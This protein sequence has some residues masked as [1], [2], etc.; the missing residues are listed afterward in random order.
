MSRQP[1]DMQGR[2]LPH[3]GGRGERG[4]YSAQNNAVDFLAVGVVIMVGP[5]LPFFLPLGSRLLMVQVPLSRERGR[6]RVWGRGK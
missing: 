5:G 4:R 6:S 3:R 2:G 1:V